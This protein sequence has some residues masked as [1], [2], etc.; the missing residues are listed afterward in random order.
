MLSRRAESTSSLSSSLFEGVTENGRQY[1][2]YKEGKYILPSDDAE[3]DR[4]DLQHHLFLMT[5]NWKL[6]LAPVNP[7]GGWVLDVGTGTGIWAID[8]AQEHPNAQ[9]IGVDLSPTQPNFVP[10]NCRFEIDDL[11]EPWTWNQKFD[12]IHARMMTSSFA[13]YP[14][15][16][17][18]CFENMA[19]GGYLEMQDCDFPLK[20]QDNTFPPN[21]ALHQWGLKIEAG[22]K[23]FGRELAATK[24][25]Q[26]M[27]DAGFVDVVEVPFVWPQNTWPKDPKLKE[28]GKWNLANS[29]DGLEGYSM[30]VMTRAFGMSS[31]AVQ[32]MMVDVRKDMIN[33]KIHAYW[34]IF[35]VYGR[36]PPLE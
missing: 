21:C 32:L 18:Q 20:C 27:L 29:L 6:N 26:Y 17:R 12:Y 10:L 19:P 8:F 13:D 1:H 24:Y 2:R 14:K 22:M 15:F 7:D 16:F 23:I 25:K 4:L 11:E 35:F 30:G 5:T 34:P 9:V 3:L 28:L 36:K 31:E 33:R